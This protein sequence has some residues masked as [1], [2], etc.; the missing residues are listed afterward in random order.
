VL[1]QQILEFFQVY[2]L[3]EVGVA[4]GCLLYRVSSVV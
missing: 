2:R 4:S 3:D 1:V